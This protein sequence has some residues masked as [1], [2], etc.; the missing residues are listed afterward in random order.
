MSTIMAAGPRL[1]APGRMPKAAP[2]PRASAT[3]RPTQE[4][5]ERKQDH[6]D[7][8]REIIPVRLGLAAVEDNVR[9]LPHRRRLVGKILKAVR[10]QRVGRIQLVE[11][12]PGVPQV[13]LH[14]AL[15]VFLADRRRDRGRRGARAGAVEPERCRAGDHRHGSLT[16][17][18]SHG[19]DRV[20]SEDRLGLLLLFLA[21]LVNGRFSLAV[22]C[23]SGREPPGRSQS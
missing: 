4:E 21:L 2:A 16:V 13:P 14:R 20:D 23:E 6:R 9:L 1:S 8:D 18:N 10:D 12:R 7:V 15:Q 5:Q 19:A 22:G 11:C 17:E 3:P